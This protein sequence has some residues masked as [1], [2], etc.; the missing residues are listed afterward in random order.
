MNSPISIKVGWL[1][2]H[3]IM[4][5]TDH[6][7]AYYLNNWNFLVSNECFEQILYSKRKCIIH[8]R[9]LG[10]ENDLNL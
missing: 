4:G 1:G 8:A 5:T 6:A 7:Y 2:S 3:Q 9:R 10:Q